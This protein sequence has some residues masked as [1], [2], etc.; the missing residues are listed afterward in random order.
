MYYP[1][2]YGIAV[3]QPVIDSLKLKDLIHAKKVKVDIDYN[4]VFEAGEF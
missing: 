4:S 2:S 1:M 3:Q